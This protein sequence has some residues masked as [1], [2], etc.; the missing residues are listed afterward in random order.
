[1]HTHPPVLVAYATRM[2]S[3]SDVAEVIGMILHEQDVSADVLSID[4]VED[5]SKYESVIIGSAI[6]GMAWLPEAVKFV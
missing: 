6:R 5:I 4:E 1:M 2:E 3:T